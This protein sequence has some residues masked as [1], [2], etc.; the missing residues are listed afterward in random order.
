MG[1]SIIGG[2]ITAKFNNIFIS[3]IGYNLV[4]LSIGMILSISLRNYSYIN[5]LTAMSATAVVTCFMIVLSIFFPILFSKLGKIL[6]VSLSTGIII[7]VIFL[8][9]G[10]NTPILNWL[11]VIV[12]SAYIG[13][14][15]YKAQNSAK[16]IPNAINSALDIYL[17][18]INLFLHLLEI[19]HKE[20]R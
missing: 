9:L 14:D 20:R 7:E 12:F 17:D 5:I 3:F 18:I 16:T 8:L 6:F 2:I 1:I 13:Y 4:I 10:V 11:F 15:W 19:E